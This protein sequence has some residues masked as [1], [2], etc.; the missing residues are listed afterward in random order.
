MSD[1]KEKYD[2]E[3]DPE[4][5]PELLL[6]LDKKTINTSSE[7]FDTRRQEIINLFYSQVYGEIPENRIELNYEIISEKK[8]FNEKAIC[9][10]VKLYLESSLNRTEVNILIYLPAKVEKPA[11]V[12]LGYNFYGNHT[13]HNDTDILITDS[14]MRNNE[15][16]G[17]YDH[18][19]TEESRGVQKDRWPVEKIIER[20]YGLAAIYYGDIAP[21]HAEEYKNGVWSLFY[22]KK[23][24]R[25]SQDWGAIS[26][27][28]WG[29]SRTLDCFEDISE[30]DQQKTIVIGHSRLGKTALWAG[31]QDDRFAAAI[32]NNSGCGGAA[33]SRR[34]FGE[35]VQKINET[36]PHWFC[37]NFRKYNN[38]EEN[39]PVDQHM[40]LA[41]IAPR[42]LYVASAEEDLWADP[43][44]EFLA[45]KEASKVYDLLGKQGLQLDS[46]PAKNT[47]AKKGMIGYHIRSG[48]H[49]LTEY[50]WQQ[51]LD[52]AD[53]HLGEGN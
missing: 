12:F 29:L 40:L 26:M 36:F 5:L 9:K 14:W 13:I 21:D 32:S 34:K 44:G 31:A 39:L 11:P 19:A 7:W 52:F 25:T 27:W 47:P 3:K 1:I 50:D 10:Q 22:D 42:P 48:G 49:D 30:I 18:E 28:A 38:K 17:I 45:A 15:E 20:G 4:N 24:K 23:T 53:F 2:P 37:K 6:S 16:Y 35:T 43:R 46:M 41:L 51:Y 33:L 8:V